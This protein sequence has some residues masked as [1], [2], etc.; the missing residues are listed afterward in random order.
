MYL[1]MNTAVADNESPFPYDLYLSQFL[2][3]TSVGN[4]E[5]IINR[6][7][8]V[9]TPYVVCARPRVEPIRPHNVPRVGHEE[10]FD[11]AHAP[12]NLGRGDVRGRPL[13]LRGQW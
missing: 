2:P 10:T 3:M 5:S 8:I 13:Y 7:E 4:R 9:C 11:T 12:L 1:F 6:I